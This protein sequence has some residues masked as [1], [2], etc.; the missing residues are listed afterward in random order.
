M[1][2]VLLGAAFILA[3]GGS[4]VAADMAIPTKAPAVVASVYNWT[5]L[6]MGGNV[7]Y[8]WDHKTTDTYDSTGLFVETTTSNGQGVIGGGQIGFNFQFAPTWL[9]GFEA[10]ISG[11][12]VHGTFSGCTATGCATNVGH[13]D[14]FGT[15]RGRVGYIVNNN[16][17]LYGTGGLAW[18]RSHNDRTVTCVVAGNGICPGGPSPSALTGMVSSPAGNNYGW[19]AGAGVEWAVVPNW[20]VKAEYLHM[21]FDNVTRNYFYPGFTT[22]SRTMHSNSDLDMVRFGFNYLFH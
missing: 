16:V 2:K 11:S 18:D 20:T 6:Y 19:T 4:A 9:V 5:G 12:D 17:L 14:Y 15:A 1:K 10:D 13:L 22:A 3:F 7:G 21:S 8:A